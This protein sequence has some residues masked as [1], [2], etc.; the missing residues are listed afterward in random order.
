[1]K[2]AGFLIERVAEMDNLLLAFYNAQK[3]KS[4]K[5]EV[6]AFRSCLQENLLKI[7][8]RLLAGDALVGNYRTFTIFDPKQRQIC[9][10]SFEERVLHHALMNVCHPYFEKHLVYDT[11][12]ARLG[13]GT[14]SALERAHKFIIRYQYVA[15]LDVRKYFDSIDHG[16]LKKQLSLLFKDPLLVRVF[17]SIIDTYHS[18]CPGVGIPIGNLTSQYF[19]NH[20]LSGFDHFVKERIRVSSYVR[21]MDDMLL[22]SNDRQLLNMQVRLVERYL[23][24]E[25]GLQIKPPVII[26]TK[27][28]VSFLGYRLQ[29]HRIGLN[30]RS[31]NRYKKKMNLYRR[32][33]DTGKWSQ[34]DYHVHVLPLTAFT[35]HA[36]SKKFRTRY[37]KSQ[38]AGLEPRESWRQL[39]QQCQ[40]LPCF[41]SQQ[42]QSLEPQQQPW[43]PGGFGPQLMDSKVDA[44]GHKQVCVLFPT[45]QGTKRAE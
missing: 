32:L 43:V 18:S 9:A 36:Y 17:N 44:D 35:E 41:E 19:A 5:K 11:Y 16:I 6:I 1:M 28:G 42:Q 13:K 38:A 31:R 15:K 14:Y 37:L 40:E 34:E 3:G 25:L 33:L 22:F 45:N 20:Y 21:Y 29:G 8:Y 26:S 2:R 39:E 4:C 12:A 23:S 7:R 24:S 10:A 30:S 27:Q